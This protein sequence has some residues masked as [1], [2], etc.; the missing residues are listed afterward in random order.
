MSLGV[1]VMAK[2]SDIIRSFIGMSALP[3]AEHSRASGVGISM[4]L[5]IMFIIMYEKHKD[6]HCDKPLQI[7]MLVMG[8]SQGNID[9][10]NS[11]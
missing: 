10:S 8:I 5:A 11:S 7:W 1:G 9:K 3:F 6:Q 2:T 4:G